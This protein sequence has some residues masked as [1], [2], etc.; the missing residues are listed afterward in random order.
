MDA[1]VYLADNLR[2]HIFRT[3]SWTKPTNLYIALLDSGQT[4][5]T[6]NGYARVQRDPADANWSDEATAGQTKNVAAITFP[7]P[8]PSD[9]SAAHWVAIFDA[10]SGGNEIGRSLL[11][12]P[13]TATTTNAAEFEAGNLTIT[14]S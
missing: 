13:F 1:S 6:G 12:S 8:T 10:S 7:T 2:D 9:W 4:E 11:D 5:L 14:V 3:S